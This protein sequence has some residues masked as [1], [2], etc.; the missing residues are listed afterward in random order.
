MTLT[1]D[2]LFL[3]EMDLILPEFQL[4]TISEVVVN[5]VEKYQ[6]AAEKNK[7]GL[8]LVIAPGLP[9]IK[10]TPTVSSVRFRPSWTM[11]SNSAPTAA[12]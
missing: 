2:I 3:Q 7:I 5:V 4:T 10:L 8:R 9:E 11:P 12:R 1:N 6:K